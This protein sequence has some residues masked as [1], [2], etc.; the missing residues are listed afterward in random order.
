V[1]F[2]SGYLVQGLF[3]PPRLGEPAPSTALP[4]RPEAQGARRLVLGEQDLEN[5]L[6]RALPGAIGVRA[7]RVIVRLPGD[8]RIQVAAQVPVGALLRGAAPTL[9]G[10]VPARWS[11]QLVWLLLVA[12]A[13]VPEGTARPQT[14]LAI[15]AAWIGTRRVPIA[16]L[17]VLLGPRVADGFR[18]PLPPGVDRIVVERG[19]VIL[20]GPS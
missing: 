11:R 1:A 2:G 15:E 7:S 3:E 13:G 16:L 5:L 9:A 17:P 10:Y 19:R 12:T 20:A 6:A 18:V 8:R 4:S 14:N